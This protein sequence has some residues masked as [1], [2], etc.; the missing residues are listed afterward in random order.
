VNASNFPESYSNSPGRSQWSWIGCEINLGT[1]DISIPS[2]WK[3]AEPL[4][5]LIVHLEGRMDEIESTIDTRLRNLNPASPGDL[6]L[7]PAN[8]IYEA[9]AK[10]GKI[11]YAELTFK[12][13]EGLTGDA[14]FNG[15]TPRQC[16]RDEFAYQCVQRLKHLTTIEQTDLIKMAGDS[17][18]MSLQLHLQL[19]PKIETQTQNGLTRSQKTLTEEYIHANLGHSLSLSDL[20]QLNSLSVHQLL[21]A[22]RSS[23]GMTPR[24]YIIEQRVQ[25]VKWLLLHSKKEIGEIALETGF[26]SQSHLSTV[27]RM[28][29]GMSPSV[30]KR[31]SS[32][33]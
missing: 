8:S 9:T 15:F 10:G 16:F 26:N 18:S 22:F 19:S 17:I 11:S 29:V 24:Q 33:S 5:T 14:A 3:I 6:W 1:E 28:R 32:Q 7:I 20:A 12:K 27:F 30:Y 4:D 31:S 2:S 23:F 21:I 13:V 25:C